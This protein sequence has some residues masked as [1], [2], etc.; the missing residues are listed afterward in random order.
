MP[1]S[2]GEQRSTDGLRQFANYIRENVEIAQQ[3][4]NDLVE[5]IAIVMSD[6]PE[7]PY[8]TVFV[9]QNEL[10]DIEISPDALVDFPDKMELSTLITSTILKAFMAYQSELSETDSN[11]M[12]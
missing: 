10:K 3:Y 1:Q 12:N 11:Q 4:G 5:D 2:Q 6:N 8:V 7:D 9:R